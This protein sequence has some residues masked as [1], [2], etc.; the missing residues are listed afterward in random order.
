MLPLM[1]LWRNIEYIMTVAILKQ[2]NDNDDNN[3]NNERMNKQRMY[4]I[5]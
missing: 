2:R 3:N 5:Y 1:S 4:Y